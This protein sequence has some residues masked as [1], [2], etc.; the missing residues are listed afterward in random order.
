MNV[1]FEAYATIL[2]RAAQ[3]KVES[4]HCD[5]CERGYVLLVIGR[6]E[7]ARAL[8][9]E[10]RKDLLAL[11]AK[12]APLQGHVACLPIRRVVCV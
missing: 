4:I 5:H 8:E 12:R 7:L 3:M 6:H 1:D 10:L 9:F 2:F 11:E